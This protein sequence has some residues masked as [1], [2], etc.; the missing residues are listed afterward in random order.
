[1]RGALFEPMPRH[2]QALSA[3]VREHDSNAY[4]FA[5]DE[6]DGARD[7]HVATDG[8]GNELDYFHSLEKLGND[9][10]FRHSGTLRVQCRSIASLARE[11]I[12]P[13]RVGILKTDT[14]GNDLFVLKGLGDVRPELVVCEYF[15]EG[16]YAGWESARP[17]LAIE[18]MRSLGYSRYIA[19]KRVGELEYCAASPGGFLPRQWGNLFFF[20]EAIFAA[21]EAALAGFLGKVEA[22]FVAKLE[23]MIADRAAKEAVIRDLARR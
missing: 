16:L 6:H 18:L 2:A 21:A 3:V 8:Q 17:E 5:I 4:D 19:T 14:E 9:E 20:K 11:G 15:T 1:M 23:A 10:R 13:A 22:Q 12:I 7:L